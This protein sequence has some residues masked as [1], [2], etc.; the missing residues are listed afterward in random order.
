MHNQKIVWSISSL[1][2]LD[3]KFRAKTHCSVSKCCWSS[4]ACLSLVSLPATE[5]EPWSFPQGLLLNKAYNLLQWAGGEKLCWLIQ[6]L[7]TYEARGNTK[8]PKSKWGLCLHVSALLYSLNCSALLLCY[9]ISKCQSSL[10]FDVL[11]V[12]ACCCRLLSVLC[13]NLDSVLLLE[14]QYNICSMLL[15]SQRENVTELD[16]GEGYEPTH[17]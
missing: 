8:Q 2:V 16:A 10:Y 14:S 6:R 17:T 9:S 1:Q 5:N 13:C 11:F 4:T 12:C 15:Q 7:Q 3:I